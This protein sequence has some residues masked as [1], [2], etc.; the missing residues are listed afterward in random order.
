[1]FLLDFVRKSL[2]DNLIPEY[3]DYTIDK[4]LNNW[5]NDNH[6]RALIMQPRLPLRL[7]YALIALEYRNH[8]NFG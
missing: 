4:F 6:V 7:R 2:P 3:N 5:S 1:M 8:I